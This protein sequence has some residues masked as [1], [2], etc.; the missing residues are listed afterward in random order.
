VGTTFSLGLD[1]SARLSLRFTH[2]V[3]RRKKRLTVSAGSLDVSGR[4]GTNRIRFQGRL[5]RTRRL[6]PGR[7]AVQVVATNATGQRTVSS[8]LRFTIVK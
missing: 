4:Q 8:R 5:S 7:Y 2:K 6:K 1:Q 3:V